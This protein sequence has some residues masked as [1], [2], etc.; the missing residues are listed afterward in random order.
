MTADDVRQVVAWLEAAGLDG[1]SLD[2]PGTT[3]RITLDDGVEVRQAA[4][5]PSPPAEPPPFLQARGTGVFLPAHPCGDAP[6]VQPGQQ[7]RAG[8]VVALLRVGPLLQPV[9]APAAGTIGG[10]L[11]APG[12][13]VGYGTPVMEFRPD[14]PPQTRSTP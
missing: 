14:A 11:A 6:L 5:A 3:L 1:F 7:V 13:T 9:T 12:S 2:T 10:C 4:S 8:E